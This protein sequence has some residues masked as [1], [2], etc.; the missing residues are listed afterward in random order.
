MANP[1]STLGIVHTAISIV[2]VIAGLY[3]FSKYGAILPRTDSGR[4][5]LI[6]LALSVLT[7]FGL[8]STGGINE[9]HVIGIVALLAAGFSLAVGR[10]GWFGR[11]GRY[12][13]TLAMSFTFF[14]LMIP[15]L[16]ETLSR[17]PPAS[18]IGNGPDSAPVQTALMIWTVIFLI[19]LCWQVWSLRRR[20][21]GAGVPV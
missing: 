9:G 2:P 11:L 17:L 1:L 7:S 12:L 8:S 20:P 21:V 16:N 5:Y 19:G 6:T 14:L 10:L 13:A 15:G 18:P 3:G 4:I